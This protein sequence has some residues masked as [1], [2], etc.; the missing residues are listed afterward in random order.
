M[1]RLL[2]IQKMMK[3]LVLAA[4]L[5]FRHAVICWRTTMSSFM[6]LRRNSNGIH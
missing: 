3:L 2:Y 5:L 4:P 1:N 6:S